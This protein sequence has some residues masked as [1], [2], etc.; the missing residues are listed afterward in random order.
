[1][2]QKILDDLIQQQKHGS[3]EVHEEDV[4]VAW[5]ADAD[6]SANPPAPAGAPPAPAGAPP[7]P[8]GGSAPAPAAGSSAPAGAGTPAAGSAAGSGA[9][10]AAAAAGSAPPAPAPAPE[11]VATND[12]LPQFNPVDKPKINHIGPKSRE[13][14]MPGLGA[15]KAAIGVL[16]DELAPG[17][18]AKKLYEGDNGAYVVLQLVNRTKPDVAEFNKTADAEIARMRKTRGIAALYGWLRARCETLAKS[19]RIAPAAEL[20]RESDE[21]GKQLATVYHACM[22]LDALEHDALDRAPFEH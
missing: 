15:S 7:A 14:A 18:V 11:I 17:N 5:Y 2:R 9:G 12:Q 16:F 19:G 21:N 22:F 13:V 1:V 8:A 20:I 4:P 3:L 6:G 10:S